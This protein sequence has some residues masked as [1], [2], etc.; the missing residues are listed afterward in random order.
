MLWVDA[1]SA[2]VTAVVLLAWVLPAME[3]WVGRR[4]A[5]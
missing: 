5:V 1:G 3:R 4:E 2:V